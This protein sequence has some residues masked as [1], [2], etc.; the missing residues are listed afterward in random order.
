MNLA[1]LK[2]RLYSEK[3]FLSETTVLQRK[4]VLGYIKEFKLRWFATQLH[5]CIVGTDFIGE[6]LSINTIE[7]H[8]SESFGIASKTYSGLPRGFQSAVAVV[9][10][11]FVDSYTTDAKEYCEL[12]QSGKKWSAFTIPVIYDIKTQSVIMFNK[13][14]LWGW[15]YYPHIKR[16]VQLLLNTDG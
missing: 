3:I 8:L 15:V 1:A 16:T 10:I 6:E 11:F 9:S 13:T 2:E 12:L 7:S 4:S 14:P 5:T